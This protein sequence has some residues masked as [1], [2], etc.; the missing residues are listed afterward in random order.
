MTAP[1][2]PAGA[3]AGWS[4]HPLESAAFARRTPSTQV[5]NLIRSP[6]RH[7]RATSRGYR[8][9]RFSGANEPRGDIFTAQSDYR[10]RL[11]SLIGCPAPPLVPCAR[12]LGQLNLG[13][14]KRLVDLSRFT[15]PRLPQYGHFI[16]TPN[17]FTSCSVLTKNAK[18]RNRP[19]SRQ[20]RD[21]VGGV[22]PAGLS[23]DRASR[24]RSSI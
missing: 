12:L 3:V 15:T 23:P 22:V 5:A 14:N 11:R 24:S 20:L 21:K 4:L 6:R 1:M 10:L 2:L 9:Q 18:Q 7:G 19:A 16:P 13:L 17:G 8:C